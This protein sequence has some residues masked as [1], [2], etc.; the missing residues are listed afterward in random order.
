[1][2][3][4]ESVEIYAKRVGH[5]PLIRFIRSSQLL[6][7][8]L[9]I[10]TRDV[11]YNESSGVLRA[12]LL[13]TSVHQGTAYGGHSIMYGIVIAAF[14]DMFTGAAAYIRA[15]TNNVVNHAETRIRYTG[16]VHIVPGTRIYTEVNVGS[17]RLR[18]RSLYCKSI[19]YQECSGARREVAQV[20]AKIPNMLE[21]VF[22]RILKRTTHL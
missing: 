11:E 16:H 9:G 17:M 15:G 10:D 18:L 14:G 8:K 12:S 20:W 3:M 22:E 6:H 1:M 4:F 21:K 7:D 19:I 5:G 2:R 13:V